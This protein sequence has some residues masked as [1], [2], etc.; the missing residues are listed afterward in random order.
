MLSRSIR[1]ALGLSTAA[2]LLS[3]AGHAADQHRGTCPV[4]PAGT[5][6]LAWDDLVD[7][8]LDEAPKVTDVRLATKRDQVRGAFAGPV[9]GELRD[10]HFTGEVIHAE[11]TSMVLLQQH[12]PGY[13]CVYQLQQLPSGDLHGV[14]HDTRALGGHHPEAARRGP[15]GAHSG[16]P[17][18]HEV[19]WMTSV[20]CCARAAGSGRSTRRWVPG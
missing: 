19:R 12:E 18:E 20:A 9:F 6:E 1:I 17:L 8:R 2:L 5:W 13:R 14:W 15:A 10:A 16:A 4:L 11:G 3:F 7:G